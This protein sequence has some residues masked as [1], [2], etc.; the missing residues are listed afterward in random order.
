MRFDLKEERGTREFPAG[1]LIVRL[2]QRAARVA[3]HILEPKGPDS[4]LH[5][6]FFNTCLQR[7]EYIEAYAIEKVAREMLAKDPKLAEEFEAKK[8]EDPEFAADPGAIRDWF[9]RRSPYYDEKAYLY[10]I[11]VRGL[12]VKNSDRHHFSK[13]KMVSVTIFH[14]TGNSNFASVSSSLPSL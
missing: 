2:D 7:V 13:R 9:Y 5:W 1:T 4:F 11:G 6:G 3:A 10:P 14:S 8:A 12:I